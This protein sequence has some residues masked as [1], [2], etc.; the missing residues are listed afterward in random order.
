MYLCSDHETWVYPLKPIKKMI[1]KTYKFVIASWLQCNVHNIPSYYICILIC[2]MPCIYLAMY[3]YII[4][5]VGGLFLVMYT[6]I[7]LSC[8]R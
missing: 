2:R 8:N 3:T 7:R 4:I 1:L 5:S 6:Y